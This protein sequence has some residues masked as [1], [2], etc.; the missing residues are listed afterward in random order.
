[1][2]D[3]ALS[4]SMRSNLQ[5]LQATADLMDRTSQRLSTQKSVNSVTDDAVK[6]FTAKNLT[7]RADRLDTVKSGIANALSAIETANTGIS[8]IRD[9]LSSMDAVI[10]QARNLVGLTDA[11][12]NA[13]R[14]DLVTQYNTLRSQINNIVDDSSY[15]GVNFLK[16]ATALTVAFNETSSTSLTVNGF[17][18]AA[19]N[20]GTGSS[21][22]GTASTTTNANGS[23]S[24]SLGSVGTVATGTGAL[25]SSTT[26]ATFGNIVVTSTPD[27][28]GGAGGTYSVT[29][30]TNTY[31]IGNGD[32]YTFGT[33]AGTITVSAAANLDAA[34]AAITVTYQEGASA[35]ANL[36]DTVSFNVDTG[37]VTSTLKNG[38]GAST[39]IVHTPGAAPT[40]AITVTG[41]GGTI[42][43]GTGVVALAT[44]GSTG[45]AL[46]TTAELDALAT[47]MTS[48]R[49]Y[50]TLNESK[51]AGNVSTLSNRQDYLSDLMATLSA[52]ADDLTK[53]DVNEEGANMLA[54]QTR[55]QLGMTSLS[56]A[57]QALQGVLRLF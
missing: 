4:A 43:G 55:Q 25:G 38:A 37:V 48:A 28:D 14:Q 18:G 34:N 16:S 49:S 22:G 31:T 50:L 44:A 41:A 33:G 12:S 20:L 6:F 54:L 2:S 10:T 3:I 30:G 47:K 36:D 15:N 5:S 29:D 32:T 27:A 57:S 35:D 45:A 39:A 51:L 8:S 7:A 26:T 21:T 56:L 24:T 17:A 9:T 11:N 1:M 52:G 23:V 53:A 13:Q 42:G 40:S 46:D 19:D